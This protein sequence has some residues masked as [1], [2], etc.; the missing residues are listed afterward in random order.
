[1]KKLLA[2]LILAAAAVV[3]VKK[4]QNAEVERDIWREAT[5]E[6]PEAENVPQELAS[7]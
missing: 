3:I 2:A 7:A 4:L 6:L 1:M 5:E